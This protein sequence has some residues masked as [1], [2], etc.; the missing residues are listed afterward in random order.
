MQSSMDAQFAFQASHAIAGDVF[1]GREPD[2]TYNQRLYHRKVIPDK[3]LR[4]VAKAAYTH[5]KN[6]QGYTLVEGLST[7]ETAVYVNA[8]NK[9]AIIGVRGT[10]NARDVWT[11]VSIARGTLGKSARYARTSRDIEVAHEALAGY[12]VS[13][14]GHSLGGSLV[15]EYTAR[16]ASMRGASFNSGYAVPWRR[17][18]RGDRVDRD[19]AEYINRNDFVSA[20]AMFRG[21]R[22]YQRRYSN[23]RYFFGAHKPLPTYWRE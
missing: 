20:G 11:D 14:T 15:N 13:I 16:N 21:S 1:V 19:Y 10:V 7:P 22:S 6:V 5:D 9:H 17:Q 2:G 12:N 4:D 23:G 8:S 18:T 3:L